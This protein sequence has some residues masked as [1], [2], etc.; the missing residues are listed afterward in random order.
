[1]A[2]QA[3]DERADPLGAA[4][5]A[6]LLEL[7]QDAVLVRDFRTKVTS[8]WNTGAER[9]YGWSKAE[10]IGRVAH[11]LLHTR[12]PVSLEA[13]D[14]ALLEHG[15]W[16]GNLVHRRRDGSQIVVFSRHAIQR[17]ARGTPMAILEIN[18]DITAE[19]QAQEDLRRSRDQLAAILAGIAEGVTVQDAQGRLVYVNEVAARM[20]GFASADEFLAAPPRQV[21]ERFAIFDEAGDPLPLEQLPGRRL[22]LGKPAMEIVVRFS[23]V[24]TNEQRWSIL[25]ATP[26]RDE[27]GQLQL[28]VNIFRD[29]TERK[30]E[31]DAS[32]FLAEASNV[33]SS[34]LDAEATLSQLAQLA[35]RGLADTCLVHLVDDRATLREVAVA[36]A[37]ED[38]GHRP[39]PSSALPD[40]TDAIERVMR[41]GGPE[42][43]EDGGSAILAP[44]RARGTTLG[45]ITLATNASGR[46]FRPADLGLVEDLSAR[47]GLAVDNARLFR[48]AQEQAEHQTMLNSALRG[49][50]NERDRALA[51][52][53]QSMRTRDEFLASASHD[54][55]N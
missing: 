48:E 24:Q 22:L 40:L 31:A 20:S 1:M 27:H 45:V 53:Q 11:E 2:D 46:R 21:L 7:T 23:D 15:F 16:E 37:N 33:L 26:V 29:I 54:L 49:M 55:K 13:V 28:V 34:S 51:D 39:R 5:D 10:A 12:F 30:R 8:Y 41:S 32:A 42:L 47:A 14:E 44:M 52:F 38:G 43:V 25:D 35:V 17:D 36:H 50:I 19:Q 6:E 4:R 18:S 3:G 9:L